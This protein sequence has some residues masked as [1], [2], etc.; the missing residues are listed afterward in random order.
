MTLMAPN[1]VAMSAAVAAL[2]A[3]VLPAFDRWARRH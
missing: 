1:L 2:I 3:V